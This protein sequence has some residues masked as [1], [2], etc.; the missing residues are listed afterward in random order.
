MIAGN[1]VAWRVTVASLVF[2]EIDLVFHNPEEIAIR[3]QKDSTH[4]LIVCFKQLLDSLL[5]VGLKP[6]VAFLCLVW[7]QK[8]A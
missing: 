3:G 1:V 6:V 5:E 2:I 7:N 8:R 4:G